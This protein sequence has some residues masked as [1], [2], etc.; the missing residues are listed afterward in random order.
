MTSAPNIRDFRTV[1]QW[2]DETARVV[3]KFGGYRLHVRRYPGRI[4]TLFLVL[5]R[6]VIMRTAGWPVSAAPRV[7]MIAPTIP[8]PAARTSRAPSRSDFR[9]A[10]HCTAPP[11]RRITSA[12]RMT[13]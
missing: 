6:G 10:V 9:T 3:W 1:I 11:V 8:I 4:R 7:E 12:G 2:D 5:F 13:P